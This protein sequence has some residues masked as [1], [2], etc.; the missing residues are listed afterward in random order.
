MANDS[1]SPTALR[2]I[3]VLIIPAIIIH[4]LTGMVLLKLSIWASDASLIWLCI[5]GA[6]ILT[7]LKGFVHLMFI[8]LLKVWDEIP[9]GSLRTVIKFAF[10]ILSVAACIFYTNTLVSHTISTGKLDVIIFG[11]LLGWMMYDYNIKI[12][13]FLRDNS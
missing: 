3:T 1:N 7:L 6:L 12:M 2:S 9:F 8:S 10:Y 4:L 5:V 13:K 11:V